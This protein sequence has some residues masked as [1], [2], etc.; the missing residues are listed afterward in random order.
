MYIIYI[1]QLFFNTFFKNNSDFKACEI[2]K[3]FSPYST[4]K[5]NIIIGP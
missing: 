2:K 5:T 3:Y 1:I 4:K